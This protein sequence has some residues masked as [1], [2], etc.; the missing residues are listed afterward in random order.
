MAPLSGAF[1][2][3]CRILFDID[4]SQGAGLL[5]VPERITTKLIET[6]LTK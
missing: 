3:Q 2:K 5:H 1:K 4:E 6:I